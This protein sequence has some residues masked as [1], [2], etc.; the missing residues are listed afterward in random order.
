MLQAGYLQESDRRSTQ[1]DLEP[2]PKEH[3]ANFQHILPR[4]FGSASL[5]LAVS[6]LN[7]GHI[8]LDA[9]D[10]STLLRDRT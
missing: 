1:R 6:Q 9:T 10:A 2:G 3:E 7:S 5:L 8:Y 4:N